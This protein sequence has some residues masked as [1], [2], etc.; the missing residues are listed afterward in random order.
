MTDQVF[1]NSVLRRVWDAFP[2]LS[3][4]ATR[5]R[6]Q[7]TLVIEPEPAHNILRF[8]REDP[9]CNY[10]LLSDVTAADYLG[11]PSETPRRFAVVWVLRSFTRD[12]L[13]LVKCWLDP[14]IDTSG[15]DED[16]ALEVASVCDI[17]PGAEWREREI[18]DMFGIRFSGHPDLR[19]ILTWTEFP[20]FPLRK[21]YPLRG[22]GERENLEVID[23]DAT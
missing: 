4:Q 8:L 16:P 2:E 17:W 12:D 14:S 22:R 3:L 5:F 18:Y 23:R 11:Y 9:D 7:V 1:D 13:L 20:A 15:N 6:G 21:D 19:R 10:E